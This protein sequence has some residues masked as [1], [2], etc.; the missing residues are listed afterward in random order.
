MKSEKEMSMGCTQLRERIVR[1][2]AGLTLV[3]LQSADFAFAV[4][5]KLA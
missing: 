3:S 5:T 2:K 4:V 1:R